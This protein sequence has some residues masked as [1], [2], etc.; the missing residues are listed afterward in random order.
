M[1]Q[2]HLR[3]EERLA[4]FAHPSTGTPRLYNFGIDICLQATVL[5]SANVGFL[6]IQSIDTPDGSSYRSPAQ[7]A[8]YVSALLSALDI[9]VVQVL[10]RRHRQHL[11]ESAAKGVSASGFRGREPILIVRNN[12]WSFWLA[13]KMAS[14]DWRCWRSMSGRTAGLQAPELR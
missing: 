2:I 11:Y 5:L 3:A 8:S 10:M 1:A 6:A 14:V 4:E 13:E 7:I 9:V 12:S